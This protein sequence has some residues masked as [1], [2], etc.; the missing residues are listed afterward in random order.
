MIIRFIL[1]FAFLL[2]LIQALFFN[3]ASGITLDYQKNGLKDTCK[4]N[5]NCW[6]AIRD[7]INGLTE[8]QVL[9]FL[10]TLGHDCDN[11]VEFS[12]YS[13]ETLFK[14]IEFNPDRFVSVIEKHQAY[15]VFN[16]IFEMIENPVKDGI[17][18]EK[19]ADLVCNIKTDSKVKSRIVESL[20]I[21]INRTK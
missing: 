3:K 15:I 13:N 5:Y 20:K 6:P 4:C 11:N 14:I 1:R 9:A 7:S 8:Q 12:E 17:D 10:Q 2:I 16:T 18:L 21:A 19:V